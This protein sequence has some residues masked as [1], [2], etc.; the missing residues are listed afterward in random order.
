[1]SDDSVA[2]LRWNALKLLHAQYEIMIATPPGVLDLAHIN[3]GL[4][5]VSFQYRSTGEYLAA[6]FASAAALSAFAVDLGLVSVEQARDAALEPFRKHPELRPEDFQPALDTLLSKEPASLPPTTEEDLR[7]AAVQR[8]REYYELSAHVQNL[9]KTSSVEPLPAGAEHH[10]SWD[11]YER[12]VGSTAARL[13]SYA[14]D[15][16]LLTPD[17]IRQ[18]LRD[19]LETHPETRTGGSG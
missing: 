16:G 8:V 2:D 19:R 10:G 17:K 1:M 6:L 15:I 3:H 7:D 11:A 13:S 18:I 12:E 5:P 14:V 4:Q 9:N